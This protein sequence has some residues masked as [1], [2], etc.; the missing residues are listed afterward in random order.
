[1]AAFSMEQGGTRAWF[2]ESDS[3]HCI[4]I[5]SIIRFSVKRCHNP[6]TQSLRTALVSWC[7]RNGILVGD[8]FFFC[9]GCV[10]LT[11]TVKVCSPSVVTSNS[12]DILNSWIRS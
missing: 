6:L 7:G 2:S 5:G 10:D 1:M 12:T 3:R 9:S 4:K 8:A 11:F